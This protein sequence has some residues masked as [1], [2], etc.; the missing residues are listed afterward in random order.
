VNWGGSESSRLLL[1]SVIIS[2]LLLLA[3]ARCARER[4]RTNRQ[5][6][7]SSGSNAKIHTKFHFGM[8]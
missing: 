2:M 6:K 3:S 8:P 1:L 7:C 4:E 5:G